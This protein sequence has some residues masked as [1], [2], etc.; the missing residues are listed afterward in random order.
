MKNVISQNIFH[1]RK[2]GKFSEFYDEKETNNKSA[3][4]VN[5]IKEEMVE[6]SD[7]SSNSNLSIYT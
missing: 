5:K 7:S 3:I 2:N 1:R 4:Y 6:V